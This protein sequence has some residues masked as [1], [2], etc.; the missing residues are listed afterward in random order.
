MN[1]VQFD[2]YKFF[3]CQSRIVVDSFSGLMDLS[4]S[5]DKFFFS[6]MIGMSL[7]YYGLSNVGFLRHQIHHQ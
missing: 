2:S 6:R 5:I 7:L 3:S 4:W 1:I